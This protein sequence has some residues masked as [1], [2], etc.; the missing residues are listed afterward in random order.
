MENDKNF[1]IGDVARTTG[2]TMKSI[3]NWEARGFIPVASRAVCGERAYRRFSMNEVENIRKIR[4][5]LDEG[6]TLSSAVN[7]TAGKNSIKEDSENE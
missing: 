6:F 4:E 3:R 2:V 5:F 1:S 7:K